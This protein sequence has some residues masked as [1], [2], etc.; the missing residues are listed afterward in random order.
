L[1][2]I[3]DDITAVQNKWPQALISLNTFMPSFV[4]VDCLVNMLFNIFLHICAESACSVG[5]G[6]ALCVTKQPEAK[7][8]LATEGERENAKERWKKSNRWTQ[9]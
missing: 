8:I 7:I 3:D 2:F 5:E 9:K 1:C 6:A 4:V